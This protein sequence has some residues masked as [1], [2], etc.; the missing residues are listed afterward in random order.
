MTVAQGLLSAQA[1]AVE[2]P[3]ECAEVLEAL[4]TSGPGAEVAVADLPP[5][6]GCDIDAKGV[7][8]A[9]VEVGLLE[10]A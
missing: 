5:V 10:V 2:F 3:I 6:E 4:L 9:L 7:A 8:Q 1:G